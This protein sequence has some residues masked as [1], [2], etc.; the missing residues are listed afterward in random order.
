MD[1]RATRKGA[2]WFL[3]L[4]L[5]PLALLFPT[6]Y[7]VT[8]PQLIGIPFFYWFQ[9]AAILVTVVLTVVAYLAGA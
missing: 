5:I 3:L 4:F 1:A 2:G 6:F 9:L 7:N 8:D